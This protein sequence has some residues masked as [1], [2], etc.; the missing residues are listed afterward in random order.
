MPDVKHFD[1]DLTLERALRLFWRRGEAATNIGDI[2]EATGVNRSSLYNAYGSKRDLYRA[3]LTRYLER[4]SQPAFDRLAADG[5]GL[6]A[7]ADFFDELVRAR[8]GGEYARWGCLVTNAHLDPAHAEPEIQ[9]VLTA[10]HQR[11]RAALRSALTAAARAGQL[12][13]GLDLDATAEQLALVA[14]G[15]NMRSRGGAPEDELRR[16]AR[17]ALAALEP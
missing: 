9:A 7:V 17:A 6:A 1:P 12:A 15:V 13:P 8:C 16:G 11:L 14:Y 4:H 3:A 5:R 10:H 2:V